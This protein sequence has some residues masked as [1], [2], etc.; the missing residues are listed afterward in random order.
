MLGNVV[1]KSL[2][3][4]ALFVSA[5]LSWPIFLDFVAGDVGATVVPVLKW[6]ESGALT[7]D[8]ALRVDA[9]TAVMLVVIN[10]VSAFVHLYSWGYMEEDDSQPRFFAYLSLFTFA[11]L[12]LVTADNL[13]QMFFGWEGVGLASYLLIGFWYHKPSANAAALKAFLVNRVGDFGF[14]LGIFGTFLAFGTI[15]IPAILE[16]SPGMAGSTI[17]FLGTRVDTM[18]LLC[19]L[20]FIG[21][22]SEER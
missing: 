22:R 15:S 4:G 16:A 10:T 1:A 14:S 21:A 20:L 12:M 2:T 9:L 17:G 7:F 19:I 11:M 6:V 8:W 3:T 18:T 5:F 13:V